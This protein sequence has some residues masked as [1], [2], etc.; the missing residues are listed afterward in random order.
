M[1]RVRAF[2]ARPPPRG[3]RRRKV[4]LVLAKEAYMDY[5]TRPT[6]PPDPFRLKWHAL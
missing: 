1:T 5:T 4:V 3:H 2:Q 6:I